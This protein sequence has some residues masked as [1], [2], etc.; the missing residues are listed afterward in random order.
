MTPLVSVLMTAY[1]REQYIAT[2]L[3]SV[4]AQSFGD[5]ELLVVDDC[6][7]DGTRDIACSYERLDRRVRVVVNER[8]LG[9]FGNRNRAAE[10]AS[11]PLLKY[12][13]SDDV[14]YPHC[15]AAMVPALRAYPEA[16]FGLTTGKDWPGG[17]CPMLLTPR[18]SYQRE[19]LGSGMF[20]AGPSGAIFRADALRALGGFQDLGIP[21]DFLFWLRACARVPVL[22]L[23]ADLFWYRIHPK[24]QLR[25][26]PA[27]R[28][29]AVLIGAV[30]AALADPACPLA[31]DEREQAR[32]NQL[33]R[34]AHRLWLDVR[35][36]RFGIACRRL[37]AGPGVADWA[38]Y[39]RRPR[40]DT[41]A[42]TPRDAH[43]DLVV[44]RTRSV[45]GAGPRA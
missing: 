39:L 7:I 9:D 33:A 5:F 20:N 12:H 34:H 21:S 44:P 8:N 24:Q 43:G 37:A 38:R 42:G 1:N 35:H 11:G 40:R 15:L 13:D 4:L 23:P 36:R 25:A 16:A 10:L 45:P 26:E 32:R 6:S 29:F 27:E 2:A 19:F 14:M 17:P 22:L 28:E 18:M 30:W 3:E 41:Y 31:P